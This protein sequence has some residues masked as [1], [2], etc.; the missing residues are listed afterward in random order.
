[1]CILIDKH[2]LRKGWGLTVFVLPR[3]NVERFCYSRNII[4]PGAVVAVNR[5][6]EALIRQSVAVLCMIIGYPV[7]HSLTAN[8]DN[9]MFELVS[10]ADQLLI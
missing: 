4:F 8:C 3:L 2:K 6:G 1:M 9:G 7:L 5:C 10:V